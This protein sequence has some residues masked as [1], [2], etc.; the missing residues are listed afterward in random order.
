MTNLV[1]HVLVVRVLLVRAVIVDVVLILCFR[2]TK[3]KF[4]TIE[5]TIVADS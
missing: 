1:L 5:T 3:T 2:P 4:I